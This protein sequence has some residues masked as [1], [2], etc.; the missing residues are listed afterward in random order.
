MPAAQ[1]QSP[2]QALRTL[3]GN[4]LGALQERVALLSLEFEEERDHLLISF[5]WLGTAMMATGLVLIF[6]SLTLVCLF[7]D[8]ARLAVLTSLTAFYALLMIGL[9]IALRRHAL[10]QPR[11]FA[12]TLVEIG[13]DQSCLRDDSK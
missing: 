11:P 9:V 2:I 10:R 4:L 3:G 1:P 5:I 12:A 6:G 13:R 8:S 7:W